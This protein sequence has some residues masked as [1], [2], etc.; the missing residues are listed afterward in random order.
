M[1]IERL[2]GKERRKLTKDDVS[3]EKIRIEYEV[4]K[5]QLVASNKELEKSQKENQ[6]DNEAYLSH[7][8]EIGRA[9][10]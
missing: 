6:T 10:V 5:K 2:R 8:F 3:T 1:K 4:L 7:R 9:H